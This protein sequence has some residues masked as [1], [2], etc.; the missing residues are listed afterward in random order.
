MQTRKLNV[1][2]DYTTQTKTDNKTS[3]PKKRFLTQEI[4]DTGMS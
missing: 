2:C 4:K 3:K 1:Y